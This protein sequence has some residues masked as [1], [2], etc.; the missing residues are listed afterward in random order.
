VTTAGRPDLLGV[1]FASDDGAKRLLVEAVDQAVVG[2][3]GQDQG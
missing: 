1:A 2:E 3:K